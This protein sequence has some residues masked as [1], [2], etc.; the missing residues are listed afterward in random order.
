MFELRAHYRCSL[1]TAKEGCENL[2]GGLTQYRLIDPNLQL[3]IVY[4]Q[5]VDVGFR[6]SFGQ[7]LCSR[8]RH[9]HKGDIAYEL[10]RLLDSG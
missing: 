6:Q 1:G 10:A 7:P 8:R 3:P 5:D 9:L 2:I 4:W